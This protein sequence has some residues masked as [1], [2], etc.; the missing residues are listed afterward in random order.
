[1]DEIVVFHAL[2]EAQVKGIAELL[3]RSMN[4]RLEDTARITLTW[5]PEAV[6]KLA[7]QGYDPAFG[8]RPLKRLIQQ[9]VETPLSR[10]IIQD[11]VKPGMTVELAAEDG[12]L[13][14][15]PKQ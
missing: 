3:L 2:G 10:L 5:T 12:Q 1:M 13:S 14:L 9:V 7:E 8:A 6:K 15:R 4:K 11:A